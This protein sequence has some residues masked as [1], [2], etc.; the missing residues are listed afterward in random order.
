MYTTYIKNPLKHNLHIT[1]N[2]MPIYFTG[3]PMAPQKVSTNLRKNKNKSLVARLEILNL[4]LRVLH[5]V[6]L[7][8]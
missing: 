7:K 6:H 8:I 5:I 1:F 3:K 2:Y 4:C